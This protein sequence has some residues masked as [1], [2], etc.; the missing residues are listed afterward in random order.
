MCTGA[1]NGGELLR[2]ITVDRSRSFTWLAFVGLRRQMHMQNRHVF[3]TCCHLYRAHVH[4]FLNK[5][6]STAALHNISFRKSWIAMRLV[7]QN[8][9]SSRE[10][11]Q[12]V[13][14]SKIAHRHKQKADTHTHTHTHTHTR[15]R[16]LEGENQTAWTRK[17]NKRE[18]GKQTCVKDKNYMREEKKQHAWRRNN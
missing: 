9:W 7:K 15:T 6:M 14:Y 8:I 10:N 17:T 11:S 18:E 4:I 16:H 2:V 3:Y 5:D 12:W 1:Q 13:P